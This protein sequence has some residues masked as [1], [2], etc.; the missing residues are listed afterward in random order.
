MSQS[1]D[2]LRDLDVF[3]IRS[4]TARAGSWAAMFRLLFDH[5]GLAA[6]S[7]DR[8]MRVMAANPEFHRFFGSGPVDVYG[9]SF[10]DLVHGDPQLHVRRQFARLV[11]DSQPQVVDRVVVAGSRYCRVIAVPVSAVEDPL[12]S[13]TTLVIPGKPALPG[14]EP[15][16]LSVLEARI[17]EGIAAGDS[18]ARLAKRLYMSQQG[19][20]YHVGAM[21]RKLRAPNRAALVA[22][23]FTTGILSAGCWPPQVLPQHIR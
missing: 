4:V 17:L 21:L 16:E 7:L 23:A 15:K 1:V 22:K 14:C 5:S 12:F 8:G 20:E 6:A 18:G 3:G 2:E 11:E 19:I 9:R 10:L 13:V